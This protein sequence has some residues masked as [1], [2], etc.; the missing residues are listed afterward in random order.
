MGVPGLNILAMASRLIVQ[1]SFVYEAFVT[2]TTNSIGLDV[3]TYATGVPMTGSVQP[4]NRKFYQFMGLDFQKNY[5]LF[6]VQKNI[7]DLT[8]DVSGDRFVFNGITYQ[9]ESKTNWFPQD[10]WDEVLCIEILPK[11]SRNA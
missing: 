4:V 2:R 7:L 6:Y 8:R 11:S 9:C 3:P 10:G 1:Q 5:V